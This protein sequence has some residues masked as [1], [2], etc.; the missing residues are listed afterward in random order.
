MLV[1]KIFYRELVA[2]ASKIF[3]V[4]VCIL[5]LTELFKLL[6]QAASG[7]IPTITLFTMMLYGTIASFPMILTIATFL[8]VVITLNRYCKDHEFA[9]WS[10]SG[11]SPFYWL[12][13]VAYFSLPLT[14]ICAAS[15]MY[16]TPWATTK[17]ESYADY[18]SKQ[19]ANMFLAPGMFRESND[20]KKVFYIEHYTLVPSLAKKIFIQYIDEDNKTY[21]ITANSGKVNNSKGIMSVMLQNGHRY[22]LNSN[23][24]Y[25]MVLNFDQFKASQEEKYTAADMKKLGINTDSIQQ[26]MGNN[27]PHAKAELSWRISIAAMMF[28]MSLIVVP[29]SIQTGRVQ[30]NLIFIFPPIFYALYENSI[31]SFNGYVSDGKVTSIMYVFAIHILIIVIA[32]FLV[33]LKTFPKGYWKSKNK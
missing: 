2:T 30:N 19:Q 12:R 20:G 11:L 10:A 28:A 7:K 29:I 21:N 32:I 6:D 14:I 5:P 13:Q 17:S 24:D 4:L 1:K 16:I 26:L 33:Y 27:D 25:Q 8:T 18:L 3:I 31:L 9:I 22:E 23:S 15:S